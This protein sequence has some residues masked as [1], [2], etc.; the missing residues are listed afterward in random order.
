MD[1]MVKDKLST[2]TAKTGTDWS[3]AKLQALT[4]DAVGHLTYTVGGT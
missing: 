3:L 2:D 1:K 4:L